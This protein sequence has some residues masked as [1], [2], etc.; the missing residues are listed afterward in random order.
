MRREDKTEADIR[1]LTHVL[2]F[3]IQEV[4]SMF[5]AAHAF[6][7]ERV[8]VLLFSADIFMLLLKT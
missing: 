8:T 1:C 4:M 7:K 3:L 5:H 2:P 6:Q